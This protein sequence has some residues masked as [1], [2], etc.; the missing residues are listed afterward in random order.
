MW[1]IEGSCAA[2]LLLFLAYISVSSVNAGKFAWLYSFR[3]ECYFYIWSLLGIWA[4]HR[5]R[6]ETLLHYF[7][8][9]KQNDNCFILILQTICIVK[10]HSDMFTLAENRQIAGMRWI[11]DAL[12]PVQPFIGKHKPLVGFH[13]SFRLHV[14]AVNNSCDPNW[15]CSQRQ[16]K[17]GR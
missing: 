9:N 7:C 12:L 2:L 16:Q 4:R 14:N 6:H 13:C 8:M 10:K 1:G 5:K 17:P 11:N 15:F 3:Q